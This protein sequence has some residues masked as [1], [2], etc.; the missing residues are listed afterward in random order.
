LFDTV[1]YLSP[2]VYWQIDDGM[3]PTLL[4]TRLEGL[5]CK[6]GSCRAFCM[7]DTTGAKER[8]FA[9]I[10]RPKAQQ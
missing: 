8:I 5:R 2:S 6:T 10:D 7:G 4:K 9:L 3:K 1:F